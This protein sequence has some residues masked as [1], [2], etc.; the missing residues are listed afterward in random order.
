MGMS[1]EGY[2][3]TSDGVIGMFIII[4]KPE[5]LRSNLKYK[6]FSWNGLFHSKPSILSNQLPLLA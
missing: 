3:H 6:L 4:M 1:F 5:F 2:V